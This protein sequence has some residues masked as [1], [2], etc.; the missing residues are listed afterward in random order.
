MSPPT[1]VLREVALPDF[2]RP[3]ELPELPVATYRARLDAAVARMR[4][5]GLD[6]LVV[7]ADRE[8][9]ANLAHL[10]GFDPRFE[11][12]VLLLDAGGKG[13]LLVGNEC[14]GQ[15]WSIFWCQKTRRWFRID[16]VSLP[17]VLGSSKTKERGTRQDSS[18]L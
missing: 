11:E 13:R 2:G 16:S 3:E 8:H 17:E 6:A 4:Q 10:T 15:I 12:A 14:L 1:A 7:Y 5:A 18:F 9:T